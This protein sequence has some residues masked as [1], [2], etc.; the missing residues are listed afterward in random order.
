MIIGEFSYREKNAV[1]I[2]I[3]Q[4]ERELMKGP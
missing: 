4:L 3:Q 2:M 1:E